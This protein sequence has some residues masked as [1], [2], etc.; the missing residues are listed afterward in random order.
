MRL[1]MS[2]T[3]YVNASGLPDD[4]QLT[5]ARDQALLGRAIQERFPRYYRYFSTTA[6]VFRGV[7]IRGHNHL[8]GSVDGVDGIKTGFTR[9]SGFNLLTSVHRDGRYIVG[10]VLGGRSAFERDA[11]M[12]ELIGDHIKEA[13]LRRSAPV[14]AERTEQREEP[15]PVAIARAPLPEKRAD[16]TPTATLN[17][18]GAAGSNDQM[19][20]VLVKT[21]SYRIAPV[22]TASLTPMPPLVPVNPQSPPPAAAQPS[23]PRA[24]YRAP[25][26]PMPMP[27]PAVEPPRT[28]VAAAEPVTALPDAPRKNEP[29][30]VAKSEQNSLPWRMAYSDR[31][32]R[33]RERGQAALERCADQASR[34]AGRGRSIHRARAK[35]RQGALPGALRRLRQGD[36]GSRLQ[37]AQAQ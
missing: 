13:A 9:A 37:A 17:T 30:N 2:H 10:V 7:T 31:R 34:H 6:F 26:A 35:G 33:R 12:R 5:S 19:R 18:H 22:Q 1:G 28:V 15:Q 27:M 20:P 11:H 25:P 16:P 4:D 14:I 29:V 32:L 3:T 24:A 8:L 21:I 36:C 23:A